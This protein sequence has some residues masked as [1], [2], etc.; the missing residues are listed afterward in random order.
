MLALCVLWLTPSSLFEAK[1]RKALLPTR[2]A[3]FFFTFWILPI[4]QL[5]DFLIEKL[6]N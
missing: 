3:P 2:T 6:L 1:K 5:R 4:K